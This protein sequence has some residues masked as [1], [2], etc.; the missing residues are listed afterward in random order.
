VFE[1]YNERDIIMI[2]SSELATESKAGLRFLVIEDL[3]ELADLMVECLR[4]RD[5]EAEV[6][7]TGEAALRL[8]SSGSFDVALVDIDLP[9]TTGFEVVAH[10]TAAGWLGR[11]RIVICTGSRLEEHRQRAARIPGSR[12]LWKPFA[13]PELMKCVNEITADLV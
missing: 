7:S 10:A 13:F 6:A 11:T 1:H 5:F 9:D 8:L 3:S 4:A 12:F 2:R